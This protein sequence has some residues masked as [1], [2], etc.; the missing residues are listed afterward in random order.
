VLAEYVRHRKILRIEEAVRKMTSFPAQRFRLVDRGL[1]RSGMWADI[2]VFDEKAVADK[3]SF[4]KPH[5]YSE[6]FAYVLVNG[7]TVVDHGTHTGARPGMMLLG[8][9]AR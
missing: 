4:P 5:A 9:A 2:V 3:A 7:E 8:P 1:I 6:G